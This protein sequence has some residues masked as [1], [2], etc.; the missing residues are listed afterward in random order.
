MYLHALGKSIVVLN[1]EEAARELLGRRNYNYND[2]PEIP[3][4][5]AYANLQGPESPF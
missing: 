2:R 3:G 5:I 4:I 1:S